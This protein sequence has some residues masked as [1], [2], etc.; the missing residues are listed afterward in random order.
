LSGQGPGLPK[1]RARLFGVETYERRPNP[2]ITALSP[3]RSPVLYTGPD[4]TTCPVPFSNRPWPYDLPPPPFVHP[5]RTRDRRPHR[6]SRPT[7]VGVLL[8]KR[9]HAVDR[10]R[11]LSNRKSGSLGI[12]VSA[13][14]LLWKCF[15]RRPIDHH[16]SSRGRSQRPYIKGRSVCFPHCICHR[17]LHTLDRPRSSW[18]KSMRLESWARDRFGPLPCTTTVGPDTIRSAS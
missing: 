5:E 12:S 15:L 2:F 11:Q 4:L 18:V 17:S 14:P 9:P 16:P 3:V 6:C 7:R 1:D 13:G 10:S 8:V